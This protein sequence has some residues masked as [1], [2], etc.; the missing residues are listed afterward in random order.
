MAESQLYAA[1]TYAAQ[2]FAQSFVRSVPTD[3]RFLQNTFQKY[4]PSTALDSDTLNFDLTRFEGA[5]FY[6]IQKTCIGLTCKITKANG[7]LPDKEKNVWPVNHVLHSLFSIVR[8]YINEQSITKQ[9]DY[10]PYKAAIT[11]ELSYSNE[12]KTCQLSTTGYYKDLAGHM[13]NSDFEINSG[14]A[15]RN[16]LFR[17]DN[18]EAKEY[19]PGTNY[20]AF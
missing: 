18:D 17:I 15:K 2:N 5:N 10:Y 20:Q 14:F 6:Q 8:V 3:A 12:Y 9:P 1:E 7:T 13:S 4:P 16:T 19:D 11:N